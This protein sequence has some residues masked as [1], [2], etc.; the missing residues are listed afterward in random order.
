[1]INQIYLGIISLFLFIFRGCP[2]WF[3]SASGHVHHLSWPA[4]PWSWRA[5]DICI[6]SWW[7]RHRWRVAQVLGTILKNKMYFHPPPV[8]LTLKG[9]LLPS[10]HSF[11][12]TP[13]L[14]WRP[15]RVLK[16]RIKCPNPACRAPPGSFLTRAG[17]APAARQVCGNS[18][19]YT[20]L[21]ERLKCHHC[22]QDKS[23]QSGWHATSPTILMH[24]PLEWGKSSLQC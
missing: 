16:T 13:V 14:F 8:P 11:F 22:T 19:F 15:V 18:N 7:R 17:Y 1:M 10:M 24:L 5:I 12:V 9:S 2:T 4:D 23:L 21:T 3:A 20:L 6:K